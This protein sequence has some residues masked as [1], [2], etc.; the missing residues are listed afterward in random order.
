MPPIA[1]QLYTV[2]QPLEHD[3]ERIVRHV[4]ATGYAG[5]ETAGIYGESPSSAARLFRDLGLEVTSIHAPLPLL[6]NLDRT[7]ELA[8]TFGIRRVVCAWYPAERF[9]T[10]DDIRA[11][12]G[13]LNRGNEVLHAQSL[14]LHYHNHWQEFGSVDGKRAYRWMLDFLD[15]TIG[16]EVDV[17]WAQTAGVDPA[18]LVRELGARAPLLHIK[19]GP[20]KKGVPMTAVGEGV[21]D[22]QA[23]AGAARST[24]EWWIV[25]LDEC[26]TDVLQAVDK[27]YTFLTGRGLANGKK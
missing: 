12:C 20:A 13:E 16:F 2:R 8:S 15:P 3:F 24:A 6:E 21:M 4:A 26:A 19:D 7:I 22:W 18:T 10:V 5:V 14:E 25:E 27:S 11:V 23:I 1:L 9:T 17:Y